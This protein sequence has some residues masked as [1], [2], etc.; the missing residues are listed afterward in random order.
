MVGLALA[1]AYDETIRRCFS[2]EVRAMRRSDAFLCTNREAPTHENDTVALTLRAGLIK[3]FGSGLYGFTPTGHRV[4]SKICSLIEREMSAIGGQQID[5]PALNHS[6]IWRRSGR[7]ENFEGEM[8]TLENR[9]GKELCLAPSHEEG[10]VH[11]VDGVVR[12]YDDLPLLLYQIDSK[13]RDDHARNGLLR[14]K[15]FTMKDAYS[16][17]NTEASLDGYYD[18]VR[19][20]YRRIVETLGIEYAI[21]RADNSVMGGST[22]EEFIAIASTGTLELR[23]CTADDCHFGVTDESPRAEL[24]AGDSC[25][26]CGSVLEA[27]E[28]VEI[29]HLF[30]L[31]TR[32]SGTT[33]L[34]VDTETGGEREV[35]MGSYGIGIERLLHVILEQHAD[36]AGCRWPGDGAGDVAP[37]DVS[38]VPLEYDGDLRGVADQMHDTLG[39][40]R[41]LLFDDPE[42][43]MGERFA[44]SDLLGIPWKVVLGN[45][46]LDTGEVEL[47]S[48]EGHTHYLDIE[49]VTDIVQT[50]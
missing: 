46:Y 23:W 14:M 20:A 47:E 4:R 36:E 13:Y 22:S 29:G 31:G 37:F 10:I 35:V 5:L 15:E 7:W 27:G 39:W 45:H 38:I 30:K 40:E 21:T 26:A 25:P 16:L 33:G 28:G 50:A 49:E 48:R 24:T 18:R 41:T 17:H 32:Y 11:L 42:Q 3:Q 34:T 19:G 12:S 6:D 9:E 1:A 8:F 2:P 43:T 44:E